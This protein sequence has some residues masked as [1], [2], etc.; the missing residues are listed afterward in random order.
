MTGLSF[1]LLAI[2]SC[3]LDFPA[4]V[5]FLFQV[6][7]LK[8]LLIELL[9]EKSPFCLSINALNLF[10]FFSNLSL[11]DVQFCAGNSFSLSVLKDFIPQS[12]AFYC[13]WY[14]SFLS[15]CHIFVFFPH[16]FGKGL[17]FLMWGYI[18]LPG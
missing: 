4:M 5:V 2:P 12:C 18:V 16:L 17:F 8:F 1:S 13:H 11:L 15:N 3:S 10:F 14:N 7:L 6:Y 9:T